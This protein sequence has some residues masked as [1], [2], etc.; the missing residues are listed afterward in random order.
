MMQAGSPALLRELCEALQI[1][2][3][4][5]VTHISIDVGIDEII[6]A[7]ITEVMEEDHIVAMKRVI[8]RKCL[9]VDEEQK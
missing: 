2:T 5:K 6:R 3:S 7:T 8:Q 9:P 4:R 1:D